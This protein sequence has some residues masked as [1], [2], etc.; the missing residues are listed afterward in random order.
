ME[1][2]I[3]RQATREDAK[4]IH[5]LHVHSVKELCKGFYSDELI[6]GWLDHRTPANFFS[7]IDRNILFVAIKD[8]EIMGFGGAIPG[9]IWAIYVS[10]GHN[11]SGI[12][13]V[14]LNHAIEIAL[15]GKDSLIVESTLNAAGFYAKNGFVE[16]ERKT[17][18]HGSVELPAILMEYKSPLKYKS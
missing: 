10:P 5:E 14:L 9:E 2:I 8:T 16:L 17:S 15:I 7:A 13:S 1:K 4:T 11:K 6:H 12:G 18:R 3:L